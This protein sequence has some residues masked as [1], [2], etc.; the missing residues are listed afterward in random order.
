MTD[1][2]CE[3]SSLA[4]DDKRVCKWTYLDRI[5]LRELACDLGGLNVNEERGTCISMLLALSCFKLMA[6]ATTP[7]PVS[8]KAWP[9]EPALEPSRG[10]SLHDDRGG[11]RFREH[12]LAAVRKCPVDLQ[13]QYK[14]LLKFLSASVVRRGT[15][16]SRV[17]GR[18]SRA[19]RSLAYIL[20]WSR[21]HPTG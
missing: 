1:R 15:I 17:S 20:N 16:H 8:T 5:E 19:K 21:R 4:K 18:H 7:S 10:I 3:A 12:N 14:V 9:R 13:V 2:S 11:S 6:L